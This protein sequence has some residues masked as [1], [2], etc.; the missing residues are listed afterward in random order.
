MDIIC[1]VIYTFLSHTKAR[2]Y[3]HY[4]LPLHSPGLFNRAKRVTINF[5]GAFFAF[6]YLFQLPFCLT[7]VFEW[8]NGTQHAI[9]FLLFVFY[10]F[11]RWSP[12]RTDV[13]GFC[14]YSRPVE[15]ID[16]LALSKG[17]VLMDADLCFSLYLFCL[18]FPFIL[19]RTDERWWCAHTLTNRPHF[20]PFLL[21]P[22]HLH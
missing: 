19:N 20:L 8:K 9:I 5:Y 3:P 1:F 13:N 10:F 12:R 11:Y 4:H 17:W 22:L 14:F 2:L 21:R 16:W 18:G 15:R 6:I 7:C